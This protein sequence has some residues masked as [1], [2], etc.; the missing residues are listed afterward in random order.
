MK[1]PQR[2]QSL[3][4]GESSSAGI[5]MSTAA[6]M[7]A[8]SVAVSVTNGSLSAAG[9]S[10]RGRRV[11]RR[12]RLRLLR[13]PRRN[14]GAGKACAKQ[15]FSARQRIV[16]HVNLPCCP[17][18]AFALRVW[19]SANPRCSFQGQV[20]SGAQGA[21]EDRSA[22]SAPPRVALPPWL[23]CLFRARD[24]TRALARTPVLPE[25]TSVGALSAQPRHS[26]PGGQA[27]DLDH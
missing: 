18:M 20:T 5:S 13:D 1:N 22:G 4:D 16:C 26:P 10:A 8:A 3:P 9:G 24:G 14:R 21:K 2:A 19:V 15:E 23:F 17:P 7:N 25:A 6:T 12:L 27:S 11:R